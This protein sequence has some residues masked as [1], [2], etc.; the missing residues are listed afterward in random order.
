L[1][2]FIYAAGNLRDP[3]QA[4]MAFRGRLPTAEALLVKRGLVPLAA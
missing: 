1:R 4:Y 2:D 3:A